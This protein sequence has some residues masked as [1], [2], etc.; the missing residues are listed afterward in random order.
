MKKL[1][2]FALATSLLALGSCASD[3]PE[4]PKGGNAEGG[5]S[6]VAVRISQNSLTRDGE[7]AP[8]ETV[9]S[10]PSEE[11]IKSVTLF[12]LDGSNNQVRRFT[13]GDIENG[14]AYFQI[15]SFAF[16]DLTKI[17]SGTTDQKK[18]QLKVYANA[19][20]NGLD[21]DTW[22][23]TGIAEADTW[24]ENQFL[25]T[26]SADLAY[27]SAP[28]TGI[29]GSDKSK[30]WIINAGGT[31]EPAIVNLTRLATRFDLLDGDGITDGEYTATEDGMQTLK[32]TIE[33]LAIHTHEKA[34]YW[35]PQGIT[36]GTRNTV[37]VNLDGARGGCK[38]TDGK[39]Q[40]K[41]FTYNLTLPGVTGDGKASTRYAH[42]HTVKADAHMGYQYLSFAAVKCSFE[43]SRIPTDATA[44]YAHNGYLLGTYA[45]FTGAEGATKIDYSKYP[46]EEQAWIA[47][48]QASSSLSEETLAEAAVKYVKN[49]DKFYCYYNMILTN[50]PNVAKDQRSRDNTAILRNT[51][52][53]ISVKS[54]A[55]LGYNED[56][57]PHDEVEDKMLFIDMQINVLPWVKNTANTN[58]P[59]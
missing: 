18:V 21:I 45:Q 12:I 48:T 44:V 37:N 55:K 10:K 38:S 26:G 41:D 30:A 31:D 2:S 35:W 4:Q 8:T 56:D 16:D 20:T 27:L 52:Y 53:Q 39:T 42:P 17:A 49:G 3:A 22:S 43:D 58:V 36:N 34:T 5:D 50:T 57:V 32:V 1:Y 7:E 51:C 15:T 14:Y 6:Y 11:N 23:A 25:M 29:D 9:S 28:G 47:A 19:S 46:G 24:T 40:F 13:T 33:G 54:I 59:L